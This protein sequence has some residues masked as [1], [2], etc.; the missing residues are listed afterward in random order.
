M[1]LEDDDCVL[2]AIRMRDCE[3]GRRRW[4]CGTSPVLNPNKIAAG[5]DFL[6]LGPS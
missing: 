4:C 1:K 6:F 2:L 3:T 5:W